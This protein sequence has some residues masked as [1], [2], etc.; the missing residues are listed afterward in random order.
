MLANKQYTIID[1]NYFNLG[2]KLCQVNLMIRKNKYLYYKFTLII[3][4]FITINRFFKAD[5]L[6]NFDIDIKYEYLIFNSYIIGDK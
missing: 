2:Q 3:E 1:I 6:N 5:L 4:K